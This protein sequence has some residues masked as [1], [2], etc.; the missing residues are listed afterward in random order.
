MPD[1][2]KFGIKTMDIAHN[3]GIDVGDPDAVEPIAEE[4]AEEYVV[5]ELFELNG[6]INAAG[7]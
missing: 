5:Q 2:E 6:A 3:R 1:Y 4:V 7:D